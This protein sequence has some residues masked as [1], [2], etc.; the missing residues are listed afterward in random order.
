MEQNVNMLE[1]LSLSNPLPSVQHQG[2]RSSLAS[3]STISS[4]RSSLYVSSWERHVHWEDGMFD[5]EEDEPGGVRGRPKRKQGSHQRSP[6]NAG[7]GRRE[8][9]MR[10]ATSPIATVKH[11]GHIV[12]ESITR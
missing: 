5:D 3:T 2:T 11:F 4:G 8:G 1:S 6:R 9:L 10:Q 12:H 7:D